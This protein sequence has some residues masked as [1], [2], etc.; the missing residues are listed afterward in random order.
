MV[1]RRLIKV[2]CK[3]ADKEADDKQ[4]K[5]FVKFETNEKST[6]ISKSKKFIYSLFPPR[7]KWCHLGR[8][9]QE[10]V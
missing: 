9:R 4:L 7:S 10:L 8:A 6:E 1:V 5:D 2:R 3:L